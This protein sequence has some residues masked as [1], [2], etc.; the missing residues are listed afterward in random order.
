MQYLF[1]CLLL[2]LLACPPPSAFCPRPPPSAPSAPAPSDGRIRLPYNTAYI[3]VDTSFSA[4][5]REHIRNAAT[6]WSLF[7]MGE[8]RLFTVD[9]LDLSGGRGALEDT[10]RIVRVTSTGNQLVSMVDAKHPGY[11]SL[12][13]TMIAPS[14]PWAPRQIYIVVDRVDP[15]QFMWVVAHEMGHFLGLNDLDQVGSVMSGVGRFRLEWFT[16]EDLRECQ[17]TKVCQ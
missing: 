6:A 8:A 5:E 16:P 13:F 3:H 1:L 2:L 11:Q 4:E 10:H 15:K 14:S 7:S 17:M 9:D 12:A